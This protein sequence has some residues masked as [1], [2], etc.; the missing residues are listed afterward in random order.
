MKYSYL[1]QEQS[2][3]CPHQNF[4]DHVFHCL[5]FPPVF[6]KQY[7]SF[8]A[9]SARFI[10]WVAASKQC[11]KRNG[12]MPIFHNKTILDNLL[13]LIKVLKDF[14]AINAIYLGLHFDKKVRNYFP[15]FL[16]L[17]RQQQNFWSLS[18]WICR[19]TN[20]K[21]NLHWLPT[22][23]TTI[24]SSTKTEQHLVIVQTS[25][26]VFGELWS[27]HQTGFCTSVKHFVSNFTNWKWVCFDD[28]E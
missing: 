11:K 17:Y 28:L 15:F 21:T 19:C 13:A 24:Y 6:G 4:R 7:F 9:K 27:E 3:D 23:S 10:S 1:I 14:P 8:V 18:F 26:Y 20:G 16:I 12:M 2:L 25:S 5:K 22:S